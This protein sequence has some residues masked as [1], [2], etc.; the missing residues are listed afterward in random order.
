MSWPGTD[1]ELEIQNRLDELEAENVKFRR[2]LRGIV[3]EILDDKHEDCEDFDEAC[4]SLMKI[5]ET[6]KAAL[7]GEETK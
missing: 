2:A 5:L 6:A 4:D 1:F 7:K 3:D